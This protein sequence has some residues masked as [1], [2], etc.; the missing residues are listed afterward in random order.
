M[1]FE[2]VQNQSHEF[3]DCTVD[4]SYDRFTS[5]FQ[6]RERE[7]VIY[8]AYLFWL[9]FRR[10]K[11]SIGAN[12]YQLTIF[13]L[14]LWSSKLHND[15]GVLIKE[16]LWWRRRKSI[17]LLIYIAIINAIRFALVLAVKT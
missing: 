12:S 10:K 6:L 9:P 1:K 8:S 4:V 17:N 16:L 5:K 7:V 2:R 11:L 3:G 15:D 14:I 13:W